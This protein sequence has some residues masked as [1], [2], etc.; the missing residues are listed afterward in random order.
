MFRGITGI[1]C[2]LLGLATGIQAQPSSSDE[3]SQLV[4]YLECPPNLQDRVTLRID[5][6]ILTN[7]DDTVRLSLGQK[8][9]QSEELSGHQLLLDEAEIPGGQYTEARLVFGAVESFAGKAQVHPQL[10]EKG[11]SIPL[12]LNARRSG[13][14]ALFLLWT[15]G[16]SAYSDGVYIPQVSV[17]KPPDLP[18][19]SMAYAANEGSNNVT[20]IDRSTYRVVDV[21]AVAKGPSD[22]AYSDLSQQLFVAGSEEDAVSVIDE[23]SREVIKQLQLNFGDT[24]SRLA[25]SPDSRYLYVLNRG[26]NTLSVIDILAFQEIARLNVGNGPVGIAVDAFTGLIYVSSKFSSDIE[27]FDPTSF[28]QVASITAGAQAGEISLNSVDK[29]LYVSHLTLRDISVVDLASGRALSSI[30]LCGNVS[31]MAFNRFVRVLYAALGDCNE[32]SLVVPDQGLE[33]GSIA[34]KGTPGRISLDG[35]NK[36]LMVCIPSQN[37]IDFYSTNSRNRLASV[38]VGK[39]PSM[40]V[41]P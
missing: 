40:I 15:P 39:N 25:L 19:G 11:V 36:Q 3:S 17:L 29:V 12:T 38:S 20:V 34:L 8:T 9:V 18:P 14:D 13:A 2:V 23:S 32:V 31:G 6:L 5:S 1:V 28:A 30:T 7:S 27:V 22:I 33:T 21:I 10:P 35:Q 16:Q 24:P 37:R 26:S 4:V 41:L